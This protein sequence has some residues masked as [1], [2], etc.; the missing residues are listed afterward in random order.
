MMGLDKW[1]ARKR[2]WRVSELVIFLYALSGGGI[3][4]YAGMYTFRHKTKK[5]IFTIGI[6]AILVLQMTVMIITIYL[7]SMK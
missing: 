3:G 5:R 6:P 2:M 4:V 7:Y 1:L